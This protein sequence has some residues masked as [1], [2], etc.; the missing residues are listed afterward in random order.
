MSG[1]MPVLEAT[2]PAAL[3]SRALD[4]RSLAVLFG[5]ARTANAFHAEPVAPETLRL[6]TELV[7]LG[8]TAM[9]AGPLRLI[10]VTT[11][12][13]KDRLRPHL[14]PGNVAKTDS[15]PVTAI[16]AMDTRFHEQLPR[17]FPARPNAGAAF[18]ENTELARDTAR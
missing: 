10:Y 2:A 17:L 6:L 3:A 4:E 18:V 7:H 9:N 12:E 15:A 11:P 5:D 8:P 14:S 16:V 1:K 13:G